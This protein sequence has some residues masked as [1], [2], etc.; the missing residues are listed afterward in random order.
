MTK[1]QNIFFT[2]KKI[3]HKHR[4]NARILFK[5][6]NN[7]IIASVNPLSNKNKKNP[8]MK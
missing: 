8:K 7:K 1:Y 2:L 3:N 5:N 4:L 6:S